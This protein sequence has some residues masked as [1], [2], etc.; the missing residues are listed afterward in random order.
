MMERLFLIHSQKYTR[1]KNVQLENT[2]HRVA[3]SVYHAHPDINVLKVARGI[4]NAN[5]ILTQPAFPHHVR[6]VRLDSAVFMKKVI[7]LENQ[8]KLT[9][10]LDIT[11]QSGTSLTQKPQ[12]GRSP[13]RLER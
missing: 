7:R 4:S 10:Q 3:V 9:V 12:I 6:N 5:Q 2:A 13:V 8:S 1:L 11:V